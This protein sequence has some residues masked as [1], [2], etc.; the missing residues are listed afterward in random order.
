MNIATE[1]RSQPQIASDP[2]SMV[3]SAAGPGRLGW[4]D[5]QGKNTAKSKNLF[6]GTYMEKQLALHGTRQAPAR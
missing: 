2:E 3:Q 1:A 4:S 5:I 6:T